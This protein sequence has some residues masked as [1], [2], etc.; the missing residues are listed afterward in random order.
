MG[1]DVLEDWVVGT[2]AL[3]LVVLTALIVGHLTGTLGLVLPEL[4]TATATILFGYLWLLTVVAANQ[5]TLTGVSAVDV[6]RE[7][8]H[9]AVG[10]A[11][12]SLVYLTVVLI[13]EFVTPTPVLLDPEPGD[14]VGVLAIGTTVGTVVGAV[15]A[16]V[17]IL[18]DRLASAVVSEPEK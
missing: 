17:F 9:A 10:G 13:V 3:V 11:V 8:V 6:R 14:V 12:I 4:E 16:T 5:L 1:S 15:L 18:S 2:G 7:L